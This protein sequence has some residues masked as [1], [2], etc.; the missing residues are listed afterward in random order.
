[1]IEQCQKLISKIQE[2]NGAPTQNFQ[3]IDVEKRPVP[4]LNVVTRSGAM[5]QV[6]NKGKQPDKAWVRKTP[7]NIPSFDIEREK[8]TFLESKRD[9][10][11]SDTSVETT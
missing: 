3:I 10:A 8:E 9:F 11:N 7:E 5:M 6:E 4:S 2:R 1:M